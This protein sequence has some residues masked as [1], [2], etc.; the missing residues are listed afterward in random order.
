MEAQDAL[1]SKTGTCSLR[2]LCL[3]LL[4]LIV[5]MLEDGRDRVQTLMKELLKTFSATNIVT[6]DQIKNVSFS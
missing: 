5:M 1:I 6:P 4:Q 3:F 2:H